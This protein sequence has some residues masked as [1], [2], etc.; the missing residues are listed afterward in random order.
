MSYKIPGIPSPKAYKEETADFWELQAIRYPDMPISQRHISKEIA[1]ALD[2]RKHDGI[3]SDDDDLDQS[4]DDILT[5]LT[6]RRKASAKKYPFEIGK[7]SIRLKSE[8]A[9]YKDLYIFLLLSTRLNM[10]KDKNQNG[11]DATLLFE[12]IC[13]I[14]VKNYLGHNT[15]SFVFGT[16]ADASFQDKVKDMIAKIGEGGYFNPPYNIDPTQKKDDGVDV[17]AYKNFAD[18]KMGKLIAFGQCKTG[19][20]SWKDGKFKLRPSDFCINW[21]ASPVVYTPLRLLFI[22]DTMN[23][24]NTFFDDQQGFIVFNRFRIMEYLPESLDNSI[25]IRV[26]KWLQGALQKIDA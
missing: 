9:I 12:E 2:E 4:F 26:K 14:A 24:G 17:V 21:F 3:E 19:T 1:I 10:T 15:Q 23:E 22:C 16:A 25:I 13:A 5:E 6:N 7:Y 20:S 8:D 11:V 18:G